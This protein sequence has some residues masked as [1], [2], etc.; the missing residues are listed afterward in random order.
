MPGSTVFST[1]IIPWSY[2]SGRARARLSE[3][4]QVSLAHSAN[5]RRSMSPVKISHDCAIHT[6]YW[7]MPVRGAHSSCC[8]VF[9][10]PDHSDQMTG[11][12]HHKLVAGVC[13][14]TIVAIVYND[15]PQVKQLTLLYL[16]CRY[17]SRTEISTAQHRV[18]LRA[19]YS[20]KSGS[21]RLF[22][23]PWCFVRHMHTTLVRMHRTSGGMAEWKKCCDEG[24]VWEG[25]PTGKE[26]EIAGFKAY[27][28]EPKDSKATSA[29]VLI[30]DV[31]GW[32]TKNIRLY[33]DLFANA[34]S[35]PGCCM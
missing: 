3:Q 25:E 7:F 20:A 15:L 12:L 22:V 30:T 28:A 14:V 21:A 23:L 31:F 8:D 1:Q 32:A 18:L 16:C 11:S 13:R 19:L 35:P 33:A 9:V 5:S 10:E 29:I 24:T 6:P 34:A 2:T 26:I 17:H 4:V 27:L